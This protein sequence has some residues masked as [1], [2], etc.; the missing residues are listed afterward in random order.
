MKPS[1]LYFIFICTVLFSCAFTSPVLGQSFDYVD[2]PVL[3]FQFTEAQIDLE[4]NPDDGSIAGSVFYDL[5]ANISGAD[6]LVLDAPGIEIESVMAG[7]KEASFKADSDTLYILVAESTEMGATYTVE[8][9]YQATPRFGLLK[10]SEETIWTS[11]LPRSVRHWLPVKDHPRVKMITSLS[12]QTPPGF[13]AFGSGVKTDDR[14]QADGSSSVTFRSGRPIPITTLAFGFGRFD[15]EGSSMGIKRINSYAEANSISAETQSELVGT[16]KQML[17]EIE[18]A[19]ELDYP[20]QR[21]H[22]VVLNDHYWEEKPYGAS[23]IFL[24]K[25]RGD[26]ENQLRRGLYAQ[27]IGVF[28]NEVQWG[29][30]RPVSFMQSTLH[31]QLSDAPAM[32]EANTD[33]PETAFST[34]YQNF[35]A[36]N[37]NFWQQYGSET[38]ANTQQLASKLM[39]VMLKEG[40]NP[41]TAASFTDAWY[42]MSG[43]PSV[44]LPVF[45]SESVTGKTT[46]VDDTV[47]YRVEFTQAAGSNRLELKFTA[48]ER[49]IQQPLGIPV[50]IISG[51]GSNTSQ[52]SF[53]G[54]NDLVSLPLPAGTRNVMLKI[55]EGRKLVFEEYKP[56]P[57]LLHQLRNAESA[58][59]KKQAAVQLGNNS[60]NPDLQ[61]ALNDLMKQNMEP[62]VEAALLQSYGKIT[63]GAEGTQ[64]RFLQALA[65][66]NRD[67]RE[68]ALEVLSNYK[69]DEVMQRMRTFSENEQDAVL[70][71]KALELYL[72]SI[73]PAA[74]LE[75]T[76]ALVQQDTAGSRA[77]LAIAALA[78][79]G[80]TDQAVKLA[81]F[82]TDA[83]FAYPVRRRAFNILLAHDSSADRW[84]ERLELFLN[85]LDPRIRF[86]TLKNIAEIPGADAGSANASQKEREYDAR[87]FQVLSK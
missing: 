20:Y 79:K 82:Y 44:D 34:P 84:S 52:I 23:T 35:S 6:T 49:G 18:Q 31:R 78:E 42:R 26:L 56:V 24:Y 17:G 25:N 65:S 71:N 33:E 43:Q 72:Q 63:A 73:E 59:A 54:T 5:K 41:I 27:W 14:L 15:V 21:L 85:D 51:G 47:R 76:N 80:S 66:E 2:R 64:E 77:I 58:E 36:E 70:S 46:A 45:D 75:Y 38:G 11:M 22:I 57:F 61:L 67:M 30:S 53:S 12:L 37:W 4:I 13:T 39:P 19:A 81:D 55:P 86:M 7:G 87:V 83:V 62:G 28:R 50:E 3:D 32:I 68:A 40:A 29:S 48:L 9:E 1:R 74:A 10:S 8:I 16:A 69:D 60:D